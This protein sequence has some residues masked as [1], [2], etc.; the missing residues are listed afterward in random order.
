MDKIKTYALLL[1]VP[2]LL[3]VTAKTLR[4]SEGP[5]YF[6][7]GYDPNYV[8]AVSSLNLINSVNAAH[9]DHPGST[10]QLLGAGFL[11]LSGK[12][13][14]QINVSV[15]SDPESYLSNFNLF[16]IFITCLCVFICGFIIFRL[17][18]KISVSMFMQITPF[19]SSTLI[20]EITQTTSEI[21][22]I[23][24]L[25]LNIALIFSAKYSAERS[26]ILK[27]SYSVFFGL[28]SGICMA[29]K[30]TFFPLLVIP[31]I[32]LPGYKNKSAFV[33]ITVI[34]FFIITYPV[35]GTYEYFMSWIGRLI[36][37]DGLYGEGNR[38]IFNLHSFS[39]NFTEMI[40]KDYLFIL[41]FISA[42]SVLIFC[43]IKVSKEEIKMNFSRKILLAIV[44]AAAIQIIAVSKHYSQHYLVPSIMLTLLMVYQIYSLCGEYEII[45]SIKNKSNFF[46]II[47]LIFAVITA[48][49]VFKVYND[50]EE[51]AE[52]T[53]RVIKIADEKADSMVI[54]N[55]YGASNRKYGLVFSMNWAGKNKEL[56]ESILNYKP[57]KRIFADFWDNKVTIYQPDDL[58]KSKLKNANSVLLRL[59]FFNF[60]K[61]A[62]SNFTNYLKEV[63]PSVEYEHR[64]IIRI[65]SGESI[66]EFLKK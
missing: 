53:K 30:I 31:L 8:Y 19:I 65:E 26:G 32:I 14:Q 54:V 64:E 15:L 57:D 49:M 66:I 36:M 7:A 18:G 40:F 29:T 47:Y 12:S 37:Y 6:N 5:Y 51:L 52:D 10:V 60:N 20:F 44:I 43:K 24:M 4:I 3:F 25:M 11:L 56:Y 28:I 58:V 42:I 38:V 61:N 45:K 63:N 23:S 50:S 33:L 13:P 48:V 46:I 22:L 62:V 16:L 1:V 27:F 35:M 41:V 59:K 21:F 9:A 39:N 55:S 17:S 2:I 34:I